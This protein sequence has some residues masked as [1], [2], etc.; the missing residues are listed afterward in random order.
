MAFLTTLHGAA[1]HGKP[2]VQNPH[3]N[4]KKKKKKKK[5]LSFLKADSKFLDSARLIKEH[6]VIIQSLT[7]GL[8]GSTKSKVGLL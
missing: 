4:P 3:F 6:T 1:M 8:S 7:A 5:R 2:R